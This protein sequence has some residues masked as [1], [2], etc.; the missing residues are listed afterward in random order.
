MT[1]LTQVPVGRGLAFP[2]FLCLVL[3]FLLHLHAFPLSALPISS[4]PFESSSIKPTL[5]LS[6]SGLGLLR[7][8]TSS[9]GCKLRPVD[10]HDPRDG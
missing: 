1:V 10:D 5:V 3:L 7:I 4:N 8:L 2:A 6:L 9:V